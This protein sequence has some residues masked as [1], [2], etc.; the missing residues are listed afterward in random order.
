VLQK[1]IRHPH[2]ANPAWEG[3]RCHCPRW[4]PPVE[5]EYSRAGKNIFY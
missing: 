3:Q 2:W 4:H 5:R 1:E